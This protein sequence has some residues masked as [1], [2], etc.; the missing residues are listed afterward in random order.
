MHRRILASLSLVCVLMVAAG[1]AQRPA[2]NDKAVWTMELLKVKPGKFW[3]TMGYLDDN[4]MRVRQEAER[5]GAVLDYR[6]IAEEDG[7]EGNQTVVLLTEYKNQAAY[8]G[9]EKLFASIL[10]KLPGKVLFFPPDDL[11][12]RLSTR[13]FDDFTDDQSV[14]LKLLA[15]E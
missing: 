4:W 9:R 6:R 10:K 8:D 1:N 12:E 13:L 3:A 11:Y 7:A 15:K 2:D 5:Q 14:H